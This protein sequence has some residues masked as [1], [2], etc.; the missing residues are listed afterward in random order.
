MSLDRNKK[1]GLVVEYYPLTNIISREHYLVDGK[2]KGRVKEFYSNGQIQSTYFIGDEGFSG[3]S[4]EWWEN[5]NK[6]SISYEDSDGTNKT[7]YRNGDIKSETEVK[8]NV[9]VSEKEWYETGENFS[10]YKSNGNRGEY[11]AWDKDGNIVS[12][13]TYIDGKLEGKVFGINGMTSKLHRTFD[14]KFE[15]TY[16]NG[17]KE[18]LYTGYSYSGKKTTVNYSNDEKDGIET[19]YH[20]NGQKQSEVE[21]SQGK[22]HGKSRG[23]RTLYWDDKGNPRK[24]VIKESSNQN[25]SRSDDGS[26]LYD[27]ALTEDEQGLGGGF[28]SDMGL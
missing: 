17:K 27:N 14:V 5:G 22:F 28:W 13:G 7:W 2:I 4:Q 9:T 15:L 24:V 18:G 8:N 10:S 6:R 16:K 19:R 26:D 25:L 3:I 20:K 1:D 11:I 12:K 23:G 21:Y